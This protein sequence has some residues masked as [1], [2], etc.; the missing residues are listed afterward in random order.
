MIKFN[1]G[2]TDHVKRALAADSNAKIEHADAPPKAKVLIASSVGHRKVPQKN[3]RR[4]LARMKVRK[5]VK[6]KFIS[7][8]L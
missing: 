5:Q 3:W 7:S 2:L 1:V 6:K 8:I 4:L